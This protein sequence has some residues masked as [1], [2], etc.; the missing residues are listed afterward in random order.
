MPIIT[1]T[2]TLRIDKL[3][4]EGYVPFVKL[5]LEQFIADHAH[6]RIK[7]DWRIWENMYYLSPWNG[8]H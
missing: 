6:V 8:L 1:T 5:E 3:K 7:I 4:S 2:A